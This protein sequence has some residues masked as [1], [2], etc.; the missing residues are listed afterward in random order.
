MFISAVGMSLFVLFSWQHGLTLH[1]LPVFFPLQYDITGHSGD[2]FDIE[3]VK[4][5]K[6]P[7]NNKERLKVLKVQ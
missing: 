7:K 2:G 5:D 1:L 6:V 4:C 3:L